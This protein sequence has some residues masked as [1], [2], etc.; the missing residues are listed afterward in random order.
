M[1]SKKL[2]D[3]RILVFGG[4]G[5]LGRAL[6]RRLGPENEVHVFSRDENK[7]W[8]LRNE[9]GRDSSV[10]FHLGDVRDPDRVM[11][12][13]KGVNPCTVINAAA[14]KHVD[15]C[16]V[17]LHECIATNVQ[18]ARN[19]ADACRR[20][21]QGNGGCP[22]VVLQVSTDKACQPVNAYGM[23]KALAER[24][25]TTQ[26]LCR[27]FSR[28]PGGFPR[29][30]AV[31]YGNVLESR[32]SIIPLFRWQAE[33]RQALTVTDPDMTRFV[34][35]LDD[36][37]DLIV[38]AIGSARHGETWIPRIPAMRIGD[39]AEL[40]SERFGKPIESIPVRP[41][42]KKHEDLVGETE[43]TRTWGTPEFW[44]DP[45]SWGISHYIIL[46]PTESLPETT[47][48]HEHLLVK[49]YRSDDDVMTKDRLREHLE[50]LGVLERPMSEFKGPS[51]EEIRT[52]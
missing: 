41:G 13:L 6:I 48:R 7:H 46:S 51:I 39:L 30:I 17:S 22:S 40:F 50:G 25:F 27:R 16:E 10:R 47:T 35:T 36:S 5:S 49:R 38:T 45:G 12:V 3:R 34:M 18:G 32:G 14:M 26:P 15:A 19:V 24:V 28:N 20:L 1:R 37:V 42:E 9:L 29:F 11:D 33:N 43:A 21:G 2:T 8:T 4:T 31:R 44:H 52:S 23:C